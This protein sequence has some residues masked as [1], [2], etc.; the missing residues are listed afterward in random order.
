MVHKAVGMLLNLL[1][2]RPDSYTPLHRW[3][4]R[5]SPVY[6]ATCDA[7]RK[8]DIAT[9]DHSASTLVHEKRAAIGE[10]KEVPR[11]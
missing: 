4:H 11:V 2:H 8:A 3:C 7:F 5:A 1:G 9:F 6:E 10:K